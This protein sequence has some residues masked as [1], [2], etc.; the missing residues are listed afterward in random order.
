M[1]AGHLSADALDDGESYAGETHHEFS[2][3]GGWDLSEAKPV[4]NHFLF[5]AFSEPKE[6]KW[7]DLNQLDD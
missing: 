1:T 3:E 4:R 2:P 5:E 6:S 7:L